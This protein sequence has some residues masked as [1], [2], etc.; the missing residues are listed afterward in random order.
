MLQLIVTREAD[1]AR[2]A[3]D[4][5]S[6]AMAQVI[7]ALRGEGIAEQDIQT[8]NFSIQPKYVYPPQ[9]SL[10]EQQPPQIVGYTVRNGLAVRVRDLGKLGA[11]MDQSVTLGVN[12]GGNI[13]FT[14]DDP[15]AAIDQA[16]ASAVKDAMARAKTLAAAAGVRVGKVLEISEQS[17][18]P[19]PVPMMRA[20]MMM[21]APAADAVPVAAGESSY[22]VTV[23]LTYAIE[24]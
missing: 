6:A 11:I 3:L 8:D 22:Q 17:Y 12:E 20:E 9:K 10:G 18:M 19:A 1:T 23:S 16:R 2:A 4:A 13:L 7:K 24:Q 5:N 21:A 14:N 15:S